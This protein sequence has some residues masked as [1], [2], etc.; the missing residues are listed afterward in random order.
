[1]VRR[2]NTFRQKSNIVKNEPA[3]AGELEEIVVKL[4]A[5]EAGGK[6]NPADL[7]DL[8]RGRRQ[9]EKL[10]LTD[11]PSLAALAD[12]MPTTQTIIKPDGPLASP[13]IA[14]AAAMQ[15]RRELPPRKLDIR[16]VEVFSPSRSSLPTQTLTADEG[17]S[18]QIIFRIAGTEA[19]ALTREKAAFHLACYV[20]NLTAGG[21]APMLGK[22]EGQLIENK[23]DYTIHTRLSNLASG[24]YRLTTVVVIVTSPRLTASYQG[25][26]FHVS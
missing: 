21:A 11:A 20:T 18:V 6:Q 13:K 22:S 8:L 4:G 12:S 17:C 15:N 26:V 24:L 3:S 2:E 16:A 23:L 5:A 14:A 25:P 10:S 9:E 7:R 1:M 19:L